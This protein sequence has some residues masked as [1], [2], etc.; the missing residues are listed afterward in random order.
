[1]LQ[2]VLADPGLQKFGEYSPAD[3]D[4]LSVDG[5]VVSENAVIHAVGVIIDRIGDDASSREVYNEVN[6]FLKN[7]I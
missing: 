2:A 7:N 1:M 3:V 6:E 4:G 5:A